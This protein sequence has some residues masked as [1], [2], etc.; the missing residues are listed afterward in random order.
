MS[1]DGFTLVEIM[2]AVAIFAV[3]V[4]VFV[5]GQGGNVLDSINI[6][7]DLELHG[8]AQNRLNEI[9]VDPPPLRESPGTRPEET[10]F[11]D[12]P[13]YVRTEEFRK[14]VLPDIELAMGLD[15]DGEGV[16]SIQRNVYNQVRQNF[17]NVLWQVEVVVRNTETGASHALSAWLINRE[18]AVRFSY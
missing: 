3:F 16:S 2:I 12:R 5:T 14:F 6:K 13:S 18:A 10:R 15:E 8:L 11:E 1:R 9:L 4:T 17:E 7:E